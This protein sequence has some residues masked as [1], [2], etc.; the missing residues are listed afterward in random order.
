MSCAVTRTLPRAR[1]TLPSSRCETPSARPISRRFRAPAARAKGQHARAADDLQIRHLGQIG[2]DFVLDCP[3]RNRRC[4]CRCS[5]CRRAAPRCFSPR[6]RRPAAPHAAP[7][8]PADAGRWTSRN[9]VATSAEGSSEM[10]ATAKWC[11]R[12]RG[13]V[14]TVRQDRPM[15]LQPADP[16]RHRKPGHQHPDYRRQGPG[17]QAQRLAHGNGQLQDQPRRRRVADRQTVHPPVFQLDEEVVHTGRASSAADFPSPCNVARSVRVFDRV[18]HNDVGRITRV[19]L[20]SEP[21]AD[22]MF[23]VSQPALRGKV[24]CRRNDEDRR[25]LVRPRLVEIDDG[26]CAARPYSL[27]GR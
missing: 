2:Q 14:S 17:R 25:R 26:F 24:V 10:S 6:G 27:A 21:D 20:D 22:L 5:G 19:G 16:Q 7:P 11:R 1:C 3:R 23:L 4:P 12:E 18:G 13:T 15:V 9:A 8:V